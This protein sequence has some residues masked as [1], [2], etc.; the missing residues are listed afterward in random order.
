MQ[1]AL[2]SLEFQW[3]FGERTGALPDGR[4]AR[5][6]LA[7]GVGSMPGLDKSGVTALMNSVTRI[8]FAET[9][10]GAVL[11]VMLHPTAVRGD[12]GLE[13]FVTL[14]KTFFRRGGYA[15]Q[16]NIIDSQTLREAQ[17][18]PERYASLQIRLTGWS[19]YFVTLPKH[20]QDQF[21]E[22]TAHT[23]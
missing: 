13:A 15:L 9:P 12:E 10:N 6:T 4:R 1:A 2:F 21:I 20:K 23:T 8:D 11:D 22:R 3:Q 19:V 17:R 14:M 5:E 16:F 18:V 7:P